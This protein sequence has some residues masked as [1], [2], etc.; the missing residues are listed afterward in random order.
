VAAG[1]P[2]QAHAAGLPGDD[3]DVAQHQRDDG[4]DQRGGPQ[5]L[6]A[7]QQVAQRGGGGQRERGQHAERALDEDV[8]RAQQPLLRQAQPEQ[9]DARVRPGE[10]QEHRQHHERRLDQRADGHPARGIRA[11]AQITPSSSRWPPNTPNASAG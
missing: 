1:D 7:Q 2:R 10:R 5:P 3:V 11:T 9:V 8:P 4:D 6:Q